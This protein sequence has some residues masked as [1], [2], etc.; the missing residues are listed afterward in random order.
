MENDQK[1]GENTWQSSISFPRTRSNR[2]AAAACRRQECSLI[3]LKAILVS[4]D[5]GA[6]AACRRAGSKRFSLGC[7]QA[8]KKKQQQKKRDK[9]PDFGMRSARAVSSG[10]I[11]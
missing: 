5:R 1:E 11:N 4:Q 7:I 2:G 10:Y 8:N 3:A 6:A 9:T